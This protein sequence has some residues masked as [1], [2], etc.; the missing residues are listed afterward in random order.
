MQLI[1]NSPYLLKITLAIQIFFFSCFNVLHLHFHRSLSFTLFPGFLVT[2]SSVDYQH[3]VGFLSLV[4]PSLSGPSWHQA[5]ARVR[6]V[7]RCFPGG[8]SG[9]GV[10]VAKETMKPLPLTSRAYS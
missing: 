6:T 1:R 7:H 2:F 4:A 3:L 9:F 5:S 10:K 8:F